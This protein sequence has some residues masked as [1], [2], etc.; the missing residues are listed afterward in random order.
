MQRAQLRPLRDADPVADE[1]DRPVRRAMQ[2]RMD[3][4]AHRMSPSP[5]HAHLQH[6]HA[7]LQRRARAVM[8]TVRSVGRH[9]RRHCARRRS[10]GRRRSSRVGAA[11]ASR[12]SHVRLRRSAQARAERAVAPGIAD[13]RADTGRRE[14]ALAKAAT[15]SRIGDLR[16]RAASGPRWPQTATLV[17]M[18]RPIRRSRRT[19]A[20]VRRTDAVGPLHQA[21]LP[22]TID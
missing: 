12:R 18:A 3:A 4:A 22:R 15:S 16:A 1:V 10:P 8:M 9:R 6:A 17:P 11:V 5:R 21:T 19:D 14:L 7:E 13:A 20:E 2:Q